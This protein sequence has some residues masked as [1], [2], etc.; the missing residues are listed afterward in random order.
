MENFR[1]PFDE[2]ALF[3]VEFIHGENI[4]PLLVDV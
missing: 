2:V 4:D 1:V 3:K